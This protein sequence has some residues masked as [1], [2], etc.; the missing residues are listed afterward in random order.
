MGFARFF[1]G[2]AQPVYLV[3]GTADEPSPGGSAA[4]GISAPIA[5]KTP[6]IRQTIATAN[7]DTVLAIP[8]GAVG[9]VLT[10]TASGA[11]AEGRVAFAPNNTAIATLTGTDDLM[12]YQPAVPAS[13]A[14]PAGMT[15][16]HVAGLVASTTVSG[17]W[18][19]NG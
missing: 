4:G 14:I 13:Y 19:F 11:F 8:A 5:G 15:H 9:V 3:S 17:S 12:G 16:L 18:L 6:G 2:T 10:F 7:Q 1:K